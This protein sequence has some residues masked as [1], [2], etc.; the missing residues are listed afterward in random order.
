MPET[1]IEPVRQQLTDS[2][3]CCAWRL[4]MLIDAL[5]FFRPND[6]VS[7]DEIDLLGRVASGNQ[8]LHDACAA[9]RS[10]CQLDLLVAI[11]T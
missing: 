11:F 10:G 8:D 9:L 5:R 2:E 6:A 7:L 4:L 3:K 1:E